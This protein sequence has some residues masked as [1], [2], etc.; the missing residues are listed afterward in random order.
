[1]VG[2]CAVA[3]HGDCSASTFVPVMYNPAVFSSSTSSSTRTARRGRRR[4]A[5]LLVPKPKPKP[6]D[7]EDSSE[8]G[9]AGW[10][11]CAIGLAGLVVAAV[12]LVILFI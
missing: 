9:Y 5:P 12:I 2:H 6:V 8:R 11:L 1:M 10:V 3:C 4:A 7:A